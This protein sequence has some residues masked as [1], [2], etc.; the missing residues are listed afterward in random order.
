M[1]FNPLGNRSS[2]ILFATIL[3]GATIFALEDTGQPLT[4]SATE[5][6]LASEDTPPNAGPFGEGGALANMPQEF[7]PDD[8]L[9]SDLIDVPDFDDVQDGEFVDDYGTQD[10]SNDYQS[11]D[12]GSGGNEEANI[13][14]SAPVIR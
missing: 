6:A 5:G 9:A 12:Y 8:E 1:T 14:S 4:S 13:Y 3:V 10:V 2:A 11:A 7:A